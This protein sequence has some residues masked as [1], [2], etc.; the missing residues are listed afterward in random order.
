LLDIN[1]ILS[2]NLFSAISLVGIQS[3]TH[4]LCVNPRGISP[5][6]DQGKSVFDG[7]V[8]EPQVS[9]IEKP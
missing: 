2:E 9:V 7:V 4:G 8:E 5:A 6:I 3:S 1:D